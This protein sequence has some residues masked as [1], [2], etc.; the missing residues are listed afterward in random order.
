[1]SKWGKQWRKDTAERVGSTLV[2]IAIPVVPT[3]A[4]TDIS[5][6]WAWITLGGPAVLTFLKCVAV[7]L[8]AP[9]SKPTAS[10]VDVTSLGAKE[11]FDAGGIE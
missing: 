2:W 8:P 9:E 4:A 5:W 1:M 3:I 7:N 6:N 11:E 10:L